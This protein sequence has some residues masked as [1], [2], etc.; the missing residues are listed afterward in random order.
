MDGM[1]L[2]IQ[3]LDTHGLARDNVFLIMDLS[4][5]YR[6]IHVLRELG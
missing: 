5:V 2:K 6:G 3:Q 4:L 1:G